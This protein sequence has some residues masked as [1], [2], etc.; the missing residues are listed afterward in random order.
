MEEEGGMEG[1][2]KNREMAVER[3]CR[4]VAGG[5]DEVMEEMEQG[6]ELEEG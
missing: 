2:G 3:R 4:K 5:E 1:E 6:G